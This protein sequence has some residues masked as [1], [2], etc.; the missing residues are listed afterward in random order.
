[1]KKKILRQYLE[2]RS[3]KEIKEVI[4]SEKSYSLEI[5][6]SSDFQLNK[7]FYKQ[8]GKKYNWVDRLIWTDKNWIEYKSNKNLLTF[9]LKK[10]NELVG[11]FELIIHKSKSEVEIVYFGILEE[12]F[13]KKLGGYLLTLALK[14]S[15]YFTDIRRVW[16][17]TC[18][19]DHK[20]G[21]KNYLSR[22]MSIFKT[23][24]LNF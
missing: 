11:Y 23:E 18:S 16:C 4:K 22:G 20:H 3:A 14:K 5:V 6:D 9:V 13:G 12:Y 2:I 15:F 24:T 8:I 10:K 17:H 7:F 19:Y 1:V 21:I